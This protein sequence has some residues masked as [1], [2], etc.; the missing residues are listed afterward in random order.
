[1][2]DSNCVGEW[3]RRS[4]ACF[5][6]MA[7]ASVASAAGPAASAASKDPFVDPLDAPALPQTRVA[8]QPAMAVARAGKRLVA[9]GM[10]GLIVMSDDEGKTWKQAAV[11]VRSDLLALS[12]PSARQG[13]AVGH[14]GVVLHSADG[15]ESWT[16]QIDGRIAATSL[17]AYYKARIARGDTSV[18][19]FLDQ[20]TLNYRNGASL[21]LLSVWF[22]DEQH[23]LAVGPFGMAIATEDGGNRWEPILDRFDNPQFLHLNGV[24]GQGG[25]IYVAAE[26]GAVFRLDAASGKFVAVRTGYAGSF[27]GVT[28]DGKALYAFGLRGTIFKSTDHGATWSTASSPLHGA[29]TGAA[30][31]PSHEGFAF[32]SAS[33][34][35][36]FYDARE[37][38]FMPIAIPR[39]AMLTGVLV[40]PGDKLA[41]TS[42]TGPVIA[43][44]RSIR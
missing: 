21:P 32:V 31:V 16:R 7:A 29:V 38:R 39:T 43:S 42:L 33:G 37:N 34:E 27:F 18:Q 25:E 20:L 30:P 3:V 14:D 2:S 13:W 19:P 36:S 40:L 28:G 24:F 6:L 44:I 15:G 41:I 17:P 9:A 11:P 23:G 8:G 5:A 35:A 26:Q 22:R 1:M 10:R 12:F 4:V